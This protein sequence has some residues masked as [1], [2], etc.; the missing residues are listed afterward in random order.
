MQ[1]DPFNRE[2]VSDKKCSL[3]NL[4][5]TLDPAYKLLEK[6]KGRS[7]ILC[8]GTTGCGKSTMLNSVVFGSDSL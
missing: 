8:F 3:E 6:Y 4:V 1:G 2:L 7:L 5:Y